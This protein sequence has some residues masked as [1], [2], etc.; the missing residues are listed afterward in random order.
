VCWELLGILNEDEPSLSSF[1]GCHSIIYPV[2]LPRWL[3]SGIVDRLTWQFQDYLR[4]ELDIMVQG[5]EQRDAIVQRKHHASHES[6]SNISVASTVRDDIG[7][8]IEFKEY[9][10]RPAETHH[11]ELI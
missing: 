9:E 8:G 1:P 5:D 3:P 2:E 11:E 6:E 10:S 4:K 7:G